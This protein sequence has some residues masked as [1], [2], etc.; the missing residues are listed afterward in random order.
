VPGCTLLP[1]GRVRR[2]TRVRETG[3]G[4]GSRLLLQGG[5]PEQRGGGYG[6]A[7]RVSAGRGV[8]GQL[9]CLGGEGWRGAEGGVGVCLCVSAVGKRWGVGEAGGCC[10][11]GYCVLIQ[12][13]RVGLHWR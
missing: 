12:G 3:R 4:Q 2:A 13:A 7:V 11:W 9:A 5:R 6:A 8:S 1:S 10:S